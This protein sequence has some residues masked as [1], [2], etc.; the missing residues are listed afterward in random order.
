MLEEFRTVGNCF[1]PERSFENAHSSNNPQSVSAIYEQ[2][3]EISI[4]LDS[5]DY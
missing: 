4:H 1:N 2:P 3:L 5:L